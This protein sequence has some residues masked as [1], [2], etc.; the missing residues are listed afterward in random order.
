MSLVTCE[1][2]CLKQL[3]KEFQF[4]EARPMTLIYRGVCGAVWFGFE[5][6][7]HLNR[8]IKKHVVWFDLV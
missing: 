1:L 3:L 5:P 7:S 2:I 4:E 6:K 8:K